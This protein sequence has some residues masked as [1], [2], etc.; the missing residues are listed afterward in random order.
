MRLTD[1][2]AIHLPIMLCEPLGGDFDG[3][4]E[5]WSPNLIN[6][7]NILIGKTKDNQQLI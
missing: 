5:T 2:Y 3:D 7:W 4:Q 1:D 6:C